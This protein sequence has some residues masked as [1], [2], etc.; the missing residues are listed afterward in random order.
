MTT[1]SW[2]DSVH[3]PSLDDRPLRQPTWKLPAWR[4]HLPLDVLADHMHIHPIVNITGHRLRLLRLDDG[5]QLL[6]CMA[7]GA[8]AGNSPRHLFEPCLGRGAGPGLARQRSRMIR[9]LH[10]HTSHG[11][12]A[13]IAGTTCPSPTQVAWLVADLR[14]ETIGR[15][16]SA[17]A[18]GS[19]G[20]EET[21]ARYGQAKLTDRVAWQ[22]RA[23]K[24][25]VPA[26]EAA[27]D[28]FW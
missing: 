26:P 19:V 18:T 20:L 1:R 7:C 4:G 10:P 17:S 27:D 9:G 25:D 8:Y 16:T 13:T 14:P 15:R 5:T 12:G 23:T 11:Q 2:S 6:A 21:F 28:G 3:L 24:P 22:T